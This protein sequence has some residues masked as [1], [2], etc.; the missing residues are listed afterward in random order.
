MN[1]HLS[2]ASK[3]HKI[4]HPHYLVLFSQWL[5]CIQ[6]LKLGRLW[7]LYH[8]RFQ[9][10]YGNSVW[11]VWILRRPWKAVPMPS[12][13][14]KRRRSFAAP[15]LH[16]CNPNG[17]V[18]LLGKAWKSIG[19]IRS[20]SSS[21]SS[22]KKGYSNITLILWFME[23]FLARKAQLHPWHMSLR[24]AL[25]A[26]RWNPIPSSPKGPLQKHHVSSHL[27]RQLDGYVN[28][29]YSTRT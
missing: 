19:N 22:S 14:P 13:Q 27:L 17:K 26:Y 6:M 4:H 1:P 25:Q 7:L 3:W 16:A 18:G 28:A 11:Q 21:S 9:N 8:N 15:Q 29:W 12:F 5:N 10:R 24:L 2:D 23:E 20:S